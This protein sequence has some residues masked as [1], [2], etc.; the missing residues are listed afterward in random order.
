[1]SDQSS[2]HDDPNWLDE[3][4]DLANQQLEDGSSCEQIHPIVEHWFDELMQNDTLDSRPSVIQAL[5]C[6]STE[7]LYNSPDEMIESLLH[8]MDEDELLIWIEHILL[9]GRAFESAL[10][11]GDLDDL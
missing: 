3:F 8:T 4:E 9:V 1:M 11:S 2:S 6:L 7:V 10:R 5:A